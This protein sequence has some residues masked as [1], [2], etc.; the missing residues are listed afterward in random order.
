MQIPYHHHGTV[1]FLTRLKREIRPD[2]VICIGDETDN[3]AVSAY[4]KHPDAAGPTAELNAAREA[5]TP[6]YK[7]FPDVSVCTSNHQARILTHA[8]RA[9][10]S[11]G[12]VRSTGEALGAPEGWVWE[13]SFFFD[14]VVYTHGDAATGV[15]AGRKHVESYGLS[16]VMG[17]IHTKQEIVYYRTN[18]GL[19]FHAYTGCLIDEKAPA[20]AYAN[21]NLSRPVL[22][23][24]AVLDGIPRLIPF[25]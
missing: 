23:S 3:H 4:H 13:R 15:Y 6:L 14:E 19:R 8:G 9:G 24:V 20:F 11:P 21:L 25:H 2:R 17:H 12:H 10:L 18:S 16:V 1:Q 22:G 7:L 5:L